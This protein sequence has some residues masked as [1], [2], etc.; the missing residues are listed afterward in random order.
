MIFDCLKSDCWAYM[1][2]R[3]RMRVDLG[4]WEGWDA[5]LD[6]FCR[7]GVGGVEGFGGVARFGEFSAFADWMH[8]SLP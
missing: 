7:A 3:G 1:G 4:H 5:Y 6:G 2:L 8:V